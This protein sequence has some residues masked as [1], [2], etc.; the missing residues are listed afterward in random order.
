[1]RGTLKLWLD[2]V[3]EQI[4]DGLEWG[5]VANRW[6]PAAHLLGLPQA[7][8]QHQWTV[9]GPTGSFPSHMPG[10]LFSAQRLVPQEL[11]KPGMLGWAL[12]EVGGESGQPSI[13]GDRS[14]G[15]STPASRLQVGQSEAH[16]TRFPTWSAT[17]LSP[18]CS[19]QQPTY[20]HT[21]PALAFSLPSP[22]PLTCFLGSPH[23]Y[24]TCSQVLAS[25]GTPTRTTVMAN[26]S[27]LK[28]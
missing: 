1:M 9:P 26:M 6:W 4:G 22:C 16:S 12:P 2:S 11:A 3:V 21:L 24:T 28:L 19:Q 8:L 7:H 23:K 13:C 14:H 5:M 25:G 15:I 18:S 10:S 20:Q 17:G 27:T